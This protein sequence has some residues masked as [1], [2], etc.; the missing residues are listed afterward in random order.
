MSK[1]AFVSAVSMLLFGFD[2][3][4]WGALVWLCRSI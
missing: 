2:F 3:L 1:R 4:F